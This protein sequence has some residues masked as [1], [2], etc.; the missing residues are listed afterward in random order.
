MSRDRPDTPSP[1][2]TFANPI[3]MDFFE[4]NQ[5]PLLRWLQRLEWAFRVFQITEDKA[6]AAYLLHFIGVEAFGILCDLLYPGDPYAQSYGLLVDKLKEF[7]APEP[8]EIAEIYIF[9]KR[10]QQPDESTQEYMAALQEL[11]LHCKFGDYLQTE[12]RNQFVFGLRNQRIQSRLLETANLTSDSALQIACVIELA[13][14][15][16]NKLK[17]EVPEAAVS[18][19]E[20]ST[21]KKLKTEEMTE[22]NTLL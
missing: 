15:G 18:G 11:S 14:K 1:G 21:K 5:Q 19:Q 13:E 10:M 7:Y 4:P 3:R 2:V 16:V 17:E 22:K 8:L 12:L 20:Q 9:R 6:K